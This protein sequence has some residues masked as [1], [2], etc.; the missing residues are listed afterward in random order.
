VLQC[1]QPNRGDAWRTTL[2]RLDAI[3]QGAPLEPSI[4]ATTELARTTAQLHIALASSAGDPNFAPETI[5]DQDTRVWRA[6]ITDEVQH[7]AQ[8][9]QRHQIQ[10]DVDGM[11]HRVDGINCLIGAHKIRHHGDY[12]LGQVLEREDGTF[13]II[14][15]EGEPSKPLALRREKRSAL[16][17]VAGMLRSFDYARNAA[18]RAGDVADPLRTARAAAW[19]AA[20]RHAFLDTYVEDVRAS[21]PSLLP[22]NIDAPLSALELEKAA[23]EALYELNNRPDW[24]PIPLAALQSPPATGTA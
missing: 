5:G 11:L 9:L 10:V 23:Y 8:A 4:A 15:F 22:A 18:L 13:V 24:V 19:Y 7:A 12:H 17:D 14:D 6:A 2:A 3:L 21:A 16:R 1:F 20:A